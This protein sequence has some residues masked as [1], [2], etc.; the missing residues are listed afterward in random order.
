M[1]L[2]RPLLAYTVKDLSAVRL[3]VLA[4][5]KL[6]GIRCLIGPNG[7]V[8]R[9]LKPIP[10]RHIRA[11]L[12]SAALLGLDGELMLRDPSATFR[13]TTSAVM[14]QDGEPDFIYWVFD[15]YAFPT[16]SFH[17]RLKVAQGTISNAMLGPVIALDHIL[18]KTLADLTLFE[19]QA[20]AQGHEGIMLR[21]PHAGYK[22]GRSTE[23]EGILGKV[24]RFSDA[25]ATCI[26]VEELFHNDNPATTNALGLT[27]RTH[28][29]AN[30]V[31]AG[32][33]GKLVLRKPDGTIFRIGTGFDAATRAELWANPPLGKLIKYKSMDFSDYDK[34]RSGVFLGIRDPSDL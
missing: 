1:L 15:C 5:A 6:D 20:V 3:P 19:E 12:N 17:A 34:P 16:M 29:Q 31:P 27:E 33:L 32:V 23:R 21:A 22:A 7:P 26:G 28:H 2:T 11:V 25:E 30:K 24:K 8:S 4:S 18:L 14:S 13:Q 10:N 9:S